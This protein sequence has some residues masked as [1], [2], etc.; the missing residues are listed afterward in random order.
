[1]WLEFLKTTLE[2]MCQKDWR[3]GE[4][5]DTLRRPEPVSSRTKAKVVVMER[6]GVIKRFRGERIKNN[7]LNKGER[8][9]NGLA[10]APYFW[11]GHCVMA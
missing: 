8:K 1:M 5:K 2:A 3:V 7:W 4:G 9:R 10:R 11:L 6:R